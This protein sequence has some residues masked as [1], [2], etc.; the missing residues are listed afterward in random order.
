MAEVYP[1]QDQKE[2]GATSEK[3]ERTVGVYKRKEKSLL[4]GKRLGIIV[5]LIVAVLIVI[6]LV[7]RTRTNTFSE[8]TPS[9]IIVTT[10]SSDMSQLIVSELRSSSKD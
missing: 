10:E 6:F 5:L 3:K 1:Q 9:S 2:N 7:F 4:G 8:W